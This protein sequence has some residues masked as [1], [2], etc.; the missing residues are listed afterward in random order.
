VRYAF[1]QATAQLL[2]RWFQ[3]TNNQR[4]GG[5]ALTS[6]VKGRGEFIWLVPNMAVQKDVESTNPS[7]DT[8][9]PG[10]I[11]SLEGVLLTGYKMTDGNMLQ[12]NVPVLLNLEFTIDR[13]YPKDIRKMIFGS[14]NVAATQNLI[15]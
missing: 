12:G 2:E 9:V 4:T 11:W 10:Q 8:L 7:D 13:Y 3:L 6:Q 5:V 1:N 14:A 15:S